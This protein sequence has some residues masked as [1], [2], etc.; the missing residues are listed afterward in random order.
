VKA[1]HLRFLSLN[2]NQ[3]QLEGTKSLA[4]IFAVAKN[5]NEVE[6]SATA[7][8]LIEV[9]TALRQLPF[10]FRVD[11]SHNSTTNAD[12]LADAIAAFLSTSNTVSNLKLKL[13]ALTPGGIH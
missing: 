4:Q 8:D 7:V 12:K 10:L 9:V 13:V 5:L 11:L 6:V 2:G 3:I 1:S